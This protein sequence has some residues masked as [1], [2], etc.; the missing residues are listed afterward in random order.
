MVYIVYGGAGYIGSYLIASLLRSNA[1]VICIDNLSNS[2]PTIFGD[3]PNNENLTLITEEDYSYT[4]IEKVQAIFHFAS[5]KSVEES[6]KNPLDYYENNIGIT[7]RALEMMRDTNCDTFIYSGSASVYGTS[8]STG[9]SENDIISPMSPYG[10]TKAVCEM[11]IKDFSNLYP[12]KRFFSLRYFN[13]YGGIENPK[14]EGNFNLI[15]ALMNAVK[16]NTPFEIFGNDYPT[17]DGTCIRD[18]IHITDLI[19]GHL[20][21]MSYDKK[22]FHVFNLGSGTQM[23]VLQVVELFKLKYPQLIVKMSPRRLGD[24]PFVFANISKAKKELFWIPKVKMSFE[25][26]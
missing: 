1:R 17:P 2:Y 9:S 24:S 7:C 10:R 12:Q 6:V 22:G 20:A 25:L 14:K 8:P 11:I 3:M 5:L 13:P 21:C 4:D 15:P 19:Q 26:F 16:N 23:T 18:Y